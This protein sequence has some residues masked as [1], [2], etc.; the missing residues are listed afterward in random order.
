MDEKHEK[1]KEDIDRTAEENVA[2]ST[3]LQS[4]RKLLVEK[5][6]EYDK[7]RTQLES[8]RP[9]VEKEQLKHSVTNIRKILEGTC[10]VEEEES[11]KFADDFLAG[12]S[13][14][15]EFL[16]DYTAIRTSHHIKKAKLDSV[17]REQ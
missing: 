17:I 14:I 10:L 16:K 11:E 7:L 2:L 4:K 13:N 12:S 1:V 3:T 8:V 5:Y 9:S 6:Q 15:E